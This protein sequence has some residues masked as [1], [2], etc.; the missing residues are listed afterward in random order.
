M[1]VVLISTPMLHE[2][3]EIY[4]DVDGSCKT[5]LGTHSDLI[6]LVSLSLV[7]T[8]SLVLITVSLSELGIVDFISCLHVDLHLQSLSISFDSIYLHRKFIVNDFLIL[9]RLFYSAVDT[10]L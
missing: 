9:T 5:P 8:M 2:T 4:L 3:R 10:V 6:P 7:L 1:K